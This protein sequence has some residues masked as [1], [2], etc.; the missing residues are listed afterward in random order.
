MDTATTIATIPIPTFSV[1][2]F[3]KMRIILHQDNM[4][5]CN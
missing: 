5:I 4:N 3:A 1:A 2:N